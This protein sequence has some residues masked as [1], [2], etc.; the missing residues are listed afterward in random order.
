MDNLAIEAENKAGQLL[1]LAPGVTLLIVMSTLAC[2]SE[3]LRMTS[4][5]PAQASSSA[6]VTSVQETVV[7]RFDSY[8]SD[9]AFVTDITVV[10]CTLENH[11]ETLCY[12]LLASSQ[13]DALV[14]SGPFCPST[15]SDEHGIFT[16]GGEHPGLYGLDQEFWEMVTSLGYSFL[17]ED[18]TINVADPR[19][20]GPGRGDLCLEAIPDDSYTLKMLIPVIPENLEVPTQLN[21][22]SQ[23]GVASDGVTIFGD[24]PTG[25]AIPALDPCGGHNDPS[26]YYHWHFGPD[27]IQ[28]NLDAEEI[29]LVCDHM[30]NAEALVGFAYDG[31]AIYGPNDFG[32]L[33]TGLDACS[34]HTGETR[35]LGTVYH[36]H[37]TYESPNL[38]EC[39]I[40]AVAREKLTSPDNPYVQLPDGIGPGAGGL[41]SSVVPPGFLEAAEA[42]GLPVDELLRALGP[43]PPDLEAA[44]ATL[45]IAV[46]TLRSVLPPPSQRR[47]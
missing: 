26:G 38:P 5:I 34:G 9:S 43:P 46:E 40:G 1:G 35:E 32:G 37:L 33:A 39:R 25:R 41:G 4:P 17:N 7:A 10:D 28:E 23:V 30:Q 24:A 16:W 3:H 20:G 36:Y 6:G 2:S 14:A 42:L 15:V 11:S 12:E 21:T 8:F 13:P 47:P 29:D 31:H 44:A 27:S 22:V 18:G 45:G 19:S